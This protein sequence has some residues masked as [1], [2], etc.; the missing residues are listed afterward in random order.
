MATTTEAPHVMVTWANAITTGR[1][2][3]E[4]FAS[5]GDA[6]EAAGDRAR[7]EWNNTRV[8]VAWHEA[9]ARADARRVM[10]EAHTGD[11]HTWGVTCRK[12]AA[13]SADRADSAAL[14]E[15]ARDAAG[16]RE[17]YAVTS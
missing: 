10:L 12:C 4:C 17:L 3:T 13:M 14:T 7:E 1:R 8:T 11:L 5:R 6:L 15:A 9:H 2:V 16:D